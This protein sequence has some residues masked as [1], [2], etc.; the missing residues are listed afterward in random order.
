MD[1]GDYVLVIEDDNGAEIDRVL[2]CAG[3]QPP[4]EGDETPLDLADVK[5]RP[6]LVGRYM[7][8]QV[9]HLPAP[10]KTSTRRRFKVPHCYVRRVRA[11]PAPESVR[12]VLDEPTVAVADL[13]HKSRELATELDDVADEVALAV[14]K[15]EVVDRQIVERLNKAS[16][17]AKQVSLTALVRTK[18]PRGSK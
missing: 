11:E 3:S 14:N 10:G 8:R 18:K 12:V 13:M 15:G 1:A 17:R 16:R 2:Q 4:R 6:H 5:D 9:A 7:V